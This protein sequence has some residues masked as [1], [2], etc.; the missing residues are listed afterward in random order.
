MPRPPNYEEEGVWGL[1]PLPTAP[2]LQKGTRSENKFLRQRVLG[3]PEKSGSMRFPACVGIASDC[4]SLLDV[5]FPLDAAASILL[6]SLS[7]FCYTINMTKMG[8]PKKPA[9]E[10]SSQLIALRLTS[11]EHKSLEQAADK[12][13]L[14]V[15]DYI[16]TKLGLRGER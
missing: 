3:V 8:R 10:R 15:S 4:K 16:R 1:C 11:A 14:S 2:A 12:A 13:K 6:D 5:A 9:K 7:T